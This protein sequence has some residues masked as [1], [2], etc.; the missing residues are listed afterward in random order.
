MGKNSCSTKMSYSNSKNFHSKKSNLTPTLMTMRTRPRLQTRKSS[1]TMM[2]THPWAKCRKCSNGTETSKS[3]LRKFSETLARNGYQK[4]N[5]LGKWTHS[6][7]VADGPSTSKEME[8]LI[9]H[10]SS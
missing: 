10:S 9:E 2:R 3:G 7:T 8:A 1:L 4:R 5:S 6:R